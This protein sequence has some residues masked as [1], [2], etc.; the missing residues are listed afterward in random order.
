MLRLQHSVRIHDPLPRKNF[1]HHD[2]V[3]EEGARSHAGRNSPRVA[4]AGDEH[5]GEGDKD[6]GN[7]GRRGLMANSLFHVFPGLIITSAAVGFMKWLWS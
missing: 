6:D 5:V 4:Q 2:E 1:D 3:E 7:A